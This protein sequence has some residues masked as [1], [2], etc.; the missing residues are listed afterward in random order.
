MIADVCF[1]DIEDNIHGGQYSEGQIIEMS[2]PCGFGK[3]DQVVGITA[4]AGE[5][6]KKSESSKFARQGE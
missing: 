3:Q 6:F 4:L 1:A 5:G 2:Y